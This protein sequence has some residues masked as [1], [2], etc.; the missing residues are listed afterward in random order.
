MLKS[1][2][3]DDKFILLNTNS[4]HSKGSSLFSGTTLFEGHTILQGHVDYTGISTLSI[5][6]LNVRAFV[7]IEN[8][9][10]TK[11]LDIHEELIMPA[12]PNK[13]REVVGVYIII[14][15][16]KCLLDMMEVNGCI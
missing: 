3:V 9:L 16:H 1:L 12:D 6:H 15:Q 5:D 10:E 7:H 2:T 11:S 8:K 13:I 4:F 14:V